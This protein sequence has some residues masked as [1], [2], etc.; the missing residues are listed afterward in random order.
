MYALIGLAV[1]ILLV[2]MAAL[3]VS[4]RMLL[5]VQDIKSD[6]YR[7]GD[8]KPRKPRAKQS[9]PEQTNLLDNVKDLP[10]RLTV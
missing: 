8:R 2:S 5:D 10:G 3:A 6:M 1:L 4:M 7:R 9:E